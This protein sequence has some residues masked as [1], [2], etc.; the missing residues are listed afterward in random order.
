MQ[1]VFP[2]L[3]H[4]EQALTH[5]QEH[6]DNGETRIPGSAA[7]DEANNYENWLK[8]MKSN[9]SS[10]GSWIPSTIFFAVTNNKI[11]GMLHI[12]HKLNDFLRNYAGHIGYSVTPSQR[13]K[14]YATKMLSLALIKCKELGIEKSTCNLL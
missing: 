3:E 4:K 7:F 1:L 13:R 12:R 11:V 14:G 9:L 5:R 10:S 8:Q 2:K 6:F